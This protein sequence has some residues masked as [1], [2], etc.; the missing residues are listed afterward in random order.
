MVWN[1]PDPKVGDLRAR[2]VFAWFPTSCALRTVWLDYAIIWEYYYPKYSNTGWVRLNVQRLK[3][4][5]GDQFEA[6]KTEL[7]KFV[8][9]E[10][11]KWLA[12]EKDPVTTAA[13]LQ[14]TN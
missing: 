8:R 4:L 13:L 14:I 10:T 5:D 2:V 11:V 9:E 7:Q 3:T 1:T 6:K 12:T